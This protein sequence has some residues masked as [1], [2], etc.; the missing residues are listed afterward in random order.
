MLTLAKKINP[1]DLEIKK[2]EKLSLEEA[3][4]FLKKIKEWDSAAK[5]DRATIIAWAEFL[6]NKGITN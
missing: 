2:E 5:F 6:K 3:T 1:K 4:I